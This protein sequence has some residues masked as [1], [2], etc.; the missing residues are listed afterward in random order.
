MSV[1]YLIITVNVTWIIDTSITIQQKQHT[2][3]VLK[4]ISYQQRQ[5]VIVLRLNV[6]TPNKPTVHFLN[7]FFPK[8][9]P[10]NIIYTEYEY[11]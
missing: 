7:V 11:L 3:V 4:T 10:L 5:L 9:C 2:T 6:R 1:V 8:E